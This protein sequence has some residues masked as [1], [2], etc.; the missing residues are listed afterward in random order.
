MADALCLID[1]IE[2]TGTANTSTCLVNLNLDDQQL[3]ATLNESASGENMSE[4]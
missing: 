3:L 1:H 4:T 2:F